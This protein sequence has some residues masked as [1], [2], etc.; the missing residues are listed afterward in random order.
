MWTQPALASVLPA[1]ITSSI[2]YQT[3]GSVRIMLRHLLT[4][5][6]NKCPPHLF[7][8]WLP[9]VLRLVLPHMYER[10]RSGWATLLASSSGAAPPPAA[11]AT[12][13]GASSTTDE[14]LADTLL[15]E[16]S[17]VGAILQSCAWRCRLKP[18]ACQPQCA[19]GL[20]AHPIP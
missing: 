11:T 20:G 19:C 13:P 7:A 16:V 12:Q 18:Q 8:H 4:P 14:V 5:W 2:Q 17:F 9:P 15:R 10:L 6:V 3:H 1:A